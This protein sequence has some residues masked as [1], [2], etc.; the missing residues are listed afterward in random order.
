MNGKPWSETDLATLREMYPTRSTREIANELRR[1]VCSVYGMANNLGLEKTPEYLQR[2]CRLQKGHTLG[3]ATQFRKGD[4][5]AN[6]G[7]KRPG[8]HVGRMKETQFKKGQRSGKAAM[9]WKPI[10]TILA[11][12]EGYLRIKVRE[13]VYGKEATGF[14]NTR[15]W[16]MLS[17]YIWE[18]HKGPIPPKHLVI[19]KDGNRENCVFDNLDLISMADNCRRN[20]MWARLPRELAVAIQLNGAL[21]NKIRRLS[22]QEQN[23]RSSGPSVRDAGSA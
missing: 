1:S 9:N 10:G 17:R 12:D 19:F 13:A 11:D 20:S 14:G 21:K 2:E 7:L 15:V 18:Q 3:R 5:P 23:E 22:G 16:P 6:K 8:W 4:A